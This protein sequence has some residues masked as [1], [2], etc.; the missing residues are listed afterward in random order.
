MIL[1]QLKIWNF[2]QF[3]SKDDSP[4][5]E[6]Q[7]HNG[8]NVLIGENDSGKSTIID[9]IKI[10][11]Q[12][13]SNEY[14]RITED[15]FYLDSA[16]NSSEIIKIEC[17]LSDFSV[18]EAKNFIEWLQFEKNDAGKTIYNLKLTFKAWKEKIEYSPICVPG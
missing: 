5:L 7:F 6:V 13:Q 17:I 16:G 3:S 10:V 14:I 15:D 2:R 11:L 9:A 4:G 18:E 12:T 8:V 1:K